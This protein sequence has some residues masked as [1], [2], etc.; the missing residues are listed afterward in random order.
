MMTRAV[1]NKTKG[2]LLILCATVLGLSVWAG[3]QPRPGTPEGAP[4]AKPRTDHQKELLTRQ[5]VG[6][7]L[8]LSAMLANPEENA[9]KQTA[10]VEVK[11]AGLELIDPAAVKEQPQQGQGHLH[12][13]ADNGP[14]I[15]TTATKLSF[16]E[17]TSGEHKITV[18][19]VGN[20]H[21]PLGPKET[22]AITIPKGKNERAQRQ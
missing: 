14:V 16:H 3:A 21:Q 15:A 1:A 19:L 13:Q 4:T 2:F 5:G 20:D 12:Y 10:T 7:P 22:L 18:M 6:H 17:L 9:Q 8:A 11:V